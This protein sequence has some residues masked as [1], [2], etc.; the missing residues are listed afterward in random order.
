MQRNTLTLL[1]VLSLSHAFGQ[2]TEFRIAFT[3]GLFSFKGNA[4]D[5][6]SPINLYGSTNNGYTN[7]PFGSSNGICDGVSLNLKRVTK[8]GLDFGLDMDFETLRSKVLI[9]GVNG[10]SD[11]ATFQYPAN[12]QTILKFNFINLYPYIGHTFGIK[13]VSVDIDGG[14]DIAYCFKSAEKGSATTSNGTKYTT[15]VERSSISTD[16]RPRIQLAADYHKIGVFI[17]YSYGL[18][19]Y[20]AK[21]TGGPLQESFARLYRF[22]VSYQLK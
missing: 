14:F 11:S 1:F 9:N 5:K 7:N 13:N 2:K 6:Y 12:G 22:G 21:Y 17:A 15:D 19:N 3:S 20:K 4:V 18:T 16:I 8:K 10:N